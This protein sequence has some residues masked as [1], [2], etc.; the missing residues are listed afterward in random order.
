MSTVYIFGGIDQY[1]FTIHVFV[2]IITNIVLIIL[3]NL[4]RVTT[5]TH[6]STYTNARFCTTLFHKHAGIRRILYE[7]II[8]VIVVALVVVKIS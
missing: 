7:D 6:A 1:S 2:N 5:G 4:N 3:I 8:I